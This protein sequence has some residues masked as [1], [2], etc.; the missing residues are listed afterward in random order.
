MI[1]NSLVNDKRVLMNTLKEDISDDRVLNAMQEVPRELFVTP[2]LKEY[3]YANAPFDIGY[4]QTI[5]QPYVVALM[6]QILELKA[7]DVVLDIGTGSGYQAAV[8][9]RLCEKVVSIE[10]IP[11]LA[12]KATNTLRELGYDNI[13]IVVGDGNEG[14]SLKG[15]YDKIVSAAAT[16]QIPNSWIDQLKNGGKIVTPMTNNSLQK[17]FSLTKQGD[18]FKKEDYGYVRFVPL[19]KG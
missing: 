2:H 15:P 13:E 11:E 3:A 10:I 5:S 7:T 18:I 14:Y 12:K 9:S 16:N 4:G 19:V 17:L 8:L 1:N 6:C